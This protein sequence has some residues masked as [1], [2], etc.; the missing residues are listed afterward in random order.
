MIKL[1]CTILI[2][3]AL[4]V[5]FAFGIMKGSALIFD[6]LRTPKVVQ[7]NIPEE[8]ATSTP[9]RAV[10]DPSKEEDPYSIIEKAVDSLPRA[11][12][13]TV[14]STAYI[15]V[16]ANTGD[17]VSER[18]ADRALP[19]ASMTK[20]ATIMTAK[21]ILDPDLRVA[22]TARELS[23]EGA[24]AKFRLGEQ[25]KVSELFYPLLMV[26]SND[27]AEVLADAYGHRQFIKAMNEW[28]SSIGAYHTYFHDPSGLSKDNVASARDVALIVQWI[29]MHNPDVLDITHLRT[30][31]IRAHTWTNATHFLNLATYRGGKNGF[32]DEAG[33]T[34]VAVF[35]VKG[36]DGRSHVYIIVVLNSANRD[37]DVLQLLEQATSK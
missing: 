31:S 33:R 5:L 36:K 22:V 27:A 15:V 25:F 16:D 13:N 26:S 28:A 6:A 2:A 1:I 14:S 37:G 4:G 30:K 10:N 23:T 8:I 12:K 7:I 20:L 29:A 3:C 11:K 17:V 21:T 19:I 32:T 35:E 24:T 34:G 9:N 18:A